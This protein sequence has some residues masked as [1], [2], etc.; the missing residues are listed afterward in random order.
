MQQEVI[1]PSGTVKLLFDQPAATLPEFYTGEDLV[2]ITNDHLARLY[3]ALF[4]GR[5]VIILP[6]G[7]HTKDLS[8]IAD[9]TRQLLKMEA[10]RSTILVGVGGG[11]ICDITGFVASIY[12]RGIRFGFIPTTLLAMVD[13]SIGGKNGVNSDL[14]KNLLGTFSHPIF[15][16]YD[17]AFLA[18][19]PGHEWSNG[20]AEIIKYACCYDE[21]LFTNLSQRFLSGYKED[22]SEIMSLVQHCAE[23]KIRVV[24]HDEKETGDRKVLNFGHTAG[25]AIEQIYELPHGQAVAIGMVLACKLSEKKS[26][27]DPSITERLQNLLQQYY[28]PFQ[29]PYDAKKVMTLLSMDK[30]RR[31]SHID[32]ILLERIGSAIITPLDLETIDSTITQY[33]TDH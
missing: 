10:T 27:L 8:F 2:W 13:A 11:V 25:H 18:T 32:Y 5:K 22:E 15:I 30:K 24:Q 28:L 9:I 17:P 3:P 31:R 16:L 6:A 23:I 4:K 26:G 20:F 14:H 12:M 7:E 19:L 33:A 29:Y 1:F 21:P